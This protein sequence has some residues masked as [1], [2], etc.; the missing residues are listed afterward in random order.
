MPD[1]D[2]VFAWLALALFVVFFIADGLARGYLHYRSTGSTGVARPGGKPRDMIG[3]TFAV[4]GMAVTVVGALLAATERLGPLPYLDYLAVRVAGLVVALIGIGAVFAAQSDMGA[5]WRANVDYGER[6]ELIRSGM[7][8]V[9]R[10]PIFTLIVLT[11]FG[12]ALMTPNVMALTGI[13]TLTVG[14][15]LHVRLV[16]EPY[17]RWAHG[18]S[19]REYAAAVGRFIPGIGRMKMDR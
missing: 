8:A 13:V 12:L 19:Y 3:A 5:S 6:T 11:M 1:M 15:D 14:I 9:I 17:L 4:A 10:N 16:E 18:D 2:T 7:F